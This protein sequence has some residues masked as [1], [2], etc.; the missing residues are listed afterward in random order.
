MPH[1]QIDVPSQYPLEVKRDLAKRLGDLYA[2]IMQT[3]SDLVHVTFRELHEGGLW[4]CGTDGPVPS[5][6]ITCD[7]RRGRPPEQRMRL[8][9]ALFDASVKALDLD[10]LTLTVEFTQHSGDEVYGK[11]LI[12]GVLTGGFGED[13]SPDEENKPLLEKLR[14]ARQGIK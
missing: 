7:I 8:A 2:E 3:S 5:A 6:V 9:E 13:W 12:D 4:R 10:P 14:E 1:L 11:M